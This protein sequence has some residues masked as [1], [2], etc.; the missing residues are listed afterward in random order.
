[1]KEERWTIRGGE[2]ARN[3]SGFTA[4]AA[5]ENAYSLKKGVVGRE[6]KRA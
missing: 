4:N 5:R 2:V 3:G 1:M 6:K